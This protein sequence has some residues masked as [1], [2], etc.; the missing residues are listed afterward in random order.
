LQT[1][2]FGENKMSDKGMGLLSNLS[3]YIASKHN[4]SPRDAVSIVMQSRIADD[5]VLD[6]TVEQLVAELID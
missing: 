2:N 3:A 5:I 6:K 4:I 1:R